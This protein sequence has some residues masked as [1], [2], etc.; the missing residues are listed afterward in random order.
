MEIAPIF[1]IYS[2]SKVEAKPVSKKRKRLQILSG[3]PE[4]S[5]Q[6]P[7]S[8]TLDEERALELFE[9]LKS[10]AKRAKVQAAE[11][12]ESTDNGWLCFNFAGLLS[13]L[14]VKIIMC[15][16]LRKQPCWPPD[17]SSALNSKLLMILYS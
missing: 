5:G 14:S 2:R 1:S 4:E 7:E 13:Q 9:A 3:N 15:S 12:S 11:G 8:L 17:K 10:K 6:A 16:T